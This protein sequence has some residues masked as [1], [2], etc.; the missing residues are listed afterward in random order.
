MKIKFLQQ[1]DNGLRIFQ[2]GIVAFLPDAEAEILI[3]N[4]T[5]ELV[6]LRSTRPIRMSVAIDYNEENKHGI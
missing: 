2:P 4:G 6:V 5:A 3:Q 1:C